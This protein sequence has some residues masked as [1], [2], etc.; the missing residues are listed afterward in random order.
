MKTSP[1]RLRVVKHQNPAEV[2]SDGGVSPQVSPAFARILRESNRPPRFLLSRMSAIGDCI[3]TLPLA[4]AIRNAFPEAHLGWVVERKAAP[5][6]RGH[7]CLDAVI[8]LERGWF[9]SSRGR[10]RAKEELRSHQFDVSIDPQGLTKSALAGY[11]SGARLRI[12]YS[13]RHGGELSRLLNNHR[14]ATAFP[15]VTDRSLELLGPLGI[16]NPEVEFRLPLQPDARRWASRYRRGVTPGRLA[17][18]NPGGTWASK[19]WPPKRFAQVAQQI[20]EVY[21]YKSLAVWGNDEERLMADEMVARS[22]GAMLLGPATDL[23]HLA[24]LIETADLFIS[25]DTGPLHMS[26]AVKTATIGLY[27][28]TKPG[29]S[30]PYRQTA[31]QKAYESGS[32]KHR[33]KADNQAMKAIQVSDVCQAIDEIEQLRRMAA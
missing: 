31:I 20:H 13:G 5:M 7:E 4:C 16:E 18:M 15:H 21:G 32:R 27:G 29:D 30:G 8:E 10:R 14:V 6:V 9:T 33:R 19:L 3:L 25:G 11:L 22:G 26:V 17:V 12:G 28:A 1:S 23:H 24:A 2:S